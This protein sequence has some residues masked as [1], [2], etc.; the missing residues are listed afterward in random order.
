MVGIDFGFL[1]FCIFLISFLLVERMHVF[2]GWDVCCEKAQ[3][4]W[5]PLHSALAVNDAR[6]PLLDPLT[7][8]PPPT[9][10]LAH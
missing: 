2:I 6:R 7:D 5:L 8:R 1:Y 4:V 9:L 10:K 3:Q